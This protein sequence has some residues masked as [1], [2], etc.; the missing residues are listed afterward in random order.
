M[1]AGEMM[2]AAAEAAAAGAEAT[3][4]MAAMVSRIHVAAARAYRAAAET[5]KLP[6]DCMAAMVSWN[7]V[8]W[9]PDIDWLG[10]QAEQTKPGSIVC[11]TC[12][13]IEPCGIDIVDEPVRDHHGQ[14]HWQATRPCVRQGQVHGTG[15]L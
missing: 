10:L 9:Q 13:T 15:N 8:R 1:S 12:K 3:K 2:R 4:G 14:V 5:S 6:L 7:C 11:L